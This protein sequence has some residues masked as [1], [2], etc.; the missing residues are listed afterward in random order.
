MLLCTVVRDLEEAKMSVSIRLWSQTPFL[1]LFTCC[2]FGEESNLSASQA[3]PLQ[4]KAGLLSGLNGW[5]VFQEP[6][7]GLGL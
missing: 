6:S 1:S 5:H 3:P 2:D 4:D 7:T